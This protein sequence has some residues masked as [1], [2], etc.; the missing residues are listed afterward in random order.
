MTLR[1]G[2]PI[3]VAGIISNVRQHDLTLKDCVLEIATPTATAVPASDPKA[4]AIPPKAHSEQTV[5]KR[6]TE[7][8]KEVYYALGALHYLIWLLV[9]IGPALGIGWLIR[10]NDSHH[11]QTAKGSRPPLPVKGVNQ[12]TRFHRKL[13]RT[14]AAH[15]K[16]LRL[17]WLN[18]STNSRQME[19]CHM[20]S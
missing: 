18:S 4:V 12:M 14:E 15:Q 8:A 10:L 6:F 19:P 20:W 5:W 3:T 1:S 11:E 13:G 17:R 16:T 9:L 7:R 2:Q